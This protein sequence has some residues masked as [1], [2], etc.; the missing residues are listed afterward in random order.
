MAKTYSRETLIAFINRA[1]TMEMLNTAEDFI[2][3][4]DLSEELREELQAEMWMRG[5]A[6]LDAQYGHGCLATAE[7][8][9]DDDY[10]PAAPWR[11]PGMRVSDFITGVYY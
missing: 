8:D 4:L 1:K 10:S 2:R 9:Y 6:I 5:D 7:D 3:K 11:A